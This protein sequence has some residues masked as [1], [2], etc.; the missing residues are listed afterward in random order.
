MLASETDSD[1]RYQ[2]YEHIVFECKFCERSDLEVEFAKE[3]HS[4][5]S[6]LTSLTNYS[7][8]LISDGQFFLGLAAAKEALNIAIQEKTI[9]NSVAVDYVRE[10]IRTKSVE[11][12]NDAL[13]ALIA[14][15]D[16][17]RTADSVLELEWMGD[18]QSLGADEGLLAIIRSIANDNI[19]R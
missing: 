17:P 19:G 6:E 15:M 11:A 10:A 12:V 14:S 13:R 7:Q 2:I 9:I 16:C 18:A 4:E 5:F 1:E 8:A 3:K